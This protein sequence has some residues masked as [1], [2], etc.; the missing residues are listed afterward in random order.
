MQSLHVLV[1]VRYRWNDRKMGCCW[2]TR[3]AALRANAQKILLIWTKVGT[4][5]PCIVPSPWPDSA[6]AQL[7]DTSRGDKR[8]WSDTIGRSLQVSRHYVGSHNDMV[9]ILQT[10][11]VWSCQEQEMLSMSFFWYWY[12]T[13]IPKHMFSKESLLGQIREVDN[14][15]FKE[16]YSQWYAVLQL[17]LHE[18]A[19]LSLIHLMCH[20]HSRPLRWQPP[21]SLP[22]TILHGR[23]SSYC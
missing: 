13:V 2:T 18:Q 22:S 14:E 20:L 12:A 11:A 19:C 21:C 23:Y 9:T 17:Q 5:I 15:Y 3:S 4:S 6:T 7:Q 10:Y 16:A 8:I 1:L